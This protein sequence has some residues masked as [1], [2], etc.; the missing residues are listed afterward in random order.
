ML[1]YSR[2]EAL[3]LI[4]SPVWL[5]HSASGESEICCS[6]ARLTALDLTTLAT[7]LRLR[8]FSGRYPNLDLHA[9]GEMDLRSAL[10]ARSQ[11]D[12]RLALRQTFSP[13]RL[14]F[15]RPSPITSRALLNFL[16]PTTRSTS[17]ML[18]KSCRLSRVEGR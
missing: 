13:S 2:I 16:S 8:T 6:F 9:L 17:S 10:F 18:G 15:P 12:E 14:T 4:R 5:L 7:S 1:Y 11:S 3:R